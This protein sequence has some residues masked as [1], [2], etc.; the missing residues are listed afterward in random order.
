[1]PTVKFGSFSKRRNSTKQPGGLSDSRNCKLK[2]T[3]SI[4]APTF[5]IQGNDFNYNYAEFEGRYY[6]I[7]D[8]RSVHNN[9]TEVDC[10]LDVLATY[11]SE[12]LNTTAYVLYDSTPNT[13]LPDN[14]LPMKTS[15]NVT[16]ATTVCPFVP[17]SG[18]YILSLTGSNDSTGVYV[19]TESE[20][21]DLVDDISFVYNNLW[22]PDPNNPRPT[23]P[24]GSQNLWDWLEYIATTCYWF[25][26]ALM[27][28]I[29]QAFGSGNIAENIRECRFIPFNVARAATPNLIYL[30]TFQTQQQLGKLARETETKTT[31]VT[32]P[33]QANDYRR[34]S[35]YTEIYLYLPYIGMVKLS[36]E[37]IVDQTSLEISYTLALRDG[38][39]I[40]TVTSGGEVLGQYSGN[41]GASVPV[42]FSNINLPKAAQSVL[43][44]IT[45]A[46]AKNYG[47]VGMAALNFGDAIMPNFTCIGGLDGVAA[48]GADQNI[49]CYVV[50]H[51]TIAEPNSALATIGSPSMC[52]KSLS[53]LTGYCQC[54]D[55]HVEA[56]A[57]SHELDQIDNFLN[58]GFYI[59]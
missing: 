18:C 1:M 4:D 43:S 32:I 57:M 37:N 54:I 51:D 7:T 47:G 12:I 53:G 39:L 40:C 49:I 34:R 9:L 27:T 31:G 21:A 58:T 48:T 29:S 56:A 35:P 36:S 2:E 6:F 45:N 52:P 41:V 16:R 8:V 19:C 33:W 26:Q 22:A 38:S 5:I 50:Y 20:L 11:K 42:G 10:E 17:D 3:T 24:T 30:G 55:A 44:G 46:A 59:E 28:P 13:E 25:F 14:R 23:K 15:K